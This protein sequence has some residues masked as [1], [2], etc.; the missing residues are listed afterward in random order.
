MPAAS[1]LFVTFEAGAYAADDLSWRPAP[2]AAGPT[3]V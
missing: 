2:D 3:N 1:L